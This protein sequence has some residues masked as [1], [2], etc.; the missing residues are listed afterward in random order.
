[1]LN[2]AIAILLIA[3]SATAQPRAGDC[4][5]G[6]GLAATLLIPYFELDLA[7]PFN[8]TTLISVNNGLNPPALSR[9]VLWTD[10]GVPTLAF[11]IYLKGFDVQTINV[12]DLFNGDDLH[13][14]IGYTSLQTLSVVAVP[15]LELIASY[16]FAD[17]DIEYA[18]GRVERLGAT[19]EWFPLPSLEVSA[20]ARHSWGGADYLIGGARNEIIAFLHLYI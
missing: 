5:I 8:V 2:L 16:E 11:D 6:P 14:L 12:R 15:G 17:A 7:H 3:G 4:V 9:V 18:R 1:M 10:W 19:V 13:E 20:M